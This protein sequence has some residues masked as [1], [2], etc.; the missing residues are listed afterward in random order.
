M[1]KQVE[2]TT[3]TTTGGVDA[4]RLESLLSRIESL[5]EE[6]RALAEDI[7]SVFAEAKGAG[8][9]VKIMRSILKIRRMNPADRQ[10][11]EFLLDTYKKALGL[12]E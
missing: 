8:Y 7:K 5:D 2:A 10:E 4:G 6:K 9:D 3:T 11:A 1:N 12:A